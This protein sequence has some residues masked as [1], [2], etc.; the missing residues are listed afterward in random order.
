MTAQ[1]GGFFR[2]NRLLAALPLEVLGR[3]ALYLEPVPLTLRAVLLQ[4]GEP[5]AYV[6]FP[7]RG[8]LCLVSVLANGRALETGLVGREGMAPVLAFLGV[9]QAPQQILIQAEGQALRIPTDVLREHAH[10]PG[11][12]HALLERYTALML[13]HT[14]ENA[15]CN[16]LHPV[17]QRLARWLLLAFDRIEEPTLQ[18]SQRFLSLLL[19]VRPASVTS[20]SVKLQR[21]GLIRHEYGRVELLDRAGLEAAACECYALMRTATEQVFS[22]AS[23]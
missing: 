22:A 2:H 9:A 14:G 3:L 15:V 20:A 18:V 10:A 19:G 12:L 13:L 21:A 8:I 5:M 7:V 6:Y 1:P 16:S 17:E 23:E 11:P 4:P